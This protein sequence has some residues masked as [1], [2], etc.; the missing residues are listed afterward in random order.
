MIQI[1]KLQDRYTDF[2]FDHPK[3]K[4]GCSWAWKIL[5][6]ALSAI[7]FAYGFRAFIAPTVQCV[8]GWFP[9]HGAADF[10]SNGLS[11]IY[12]GV[13]QNDFIDPNHLI[14]GGASGISQSIIRF[15][16][17]FANIKGQEKL[18]TSLLYFVINVPLLILA[19]FKISKSFA[20]STLINVGFVS[21]FNYIIPDA[22]IYNIVN[23]YTNTLARCIFGGITTGLSSGLA[24]IVNSSAGGTDIL[25]IYFSEKKHSQVGKISFIINGMIIISYTL[26][27]V[28]GQ[29]TNPSW[30]TGSSN[31]VIT[32]ALYSIVY[33]FR[34]TKVIDLRNVRNRKQ[35]LTI[36]TNDEDRP[37]VL[38]RAF[39]HTATVVQGKGAYSG[40]EKLVIY[41]VISK[42]EEKKAISLIRKADPN[43]FL[44][45]CD[46]NQVYG[47][48]FIK[49]LE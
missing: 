21:L 26:F 28:I 11:L 24:R 29:F 39:P 1:K 8:A 4:I 30:N 16:E 46:L 12:N 44:T 41:R 38:I 37:K 47:R 35:Q 36:F 42:P 15:V 49:P 48:F 9:K 31:D 20:V 3:T 34:A 18:I 43:A 2:L 33:Y 27:T 22:W 25:S 19:F 40:Q 17:I 13:S 5:V 10:D 7:I 32:R 23:L 6:T 14:A 45:V